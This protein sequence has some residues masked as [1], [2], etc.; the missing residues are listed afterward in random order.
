LH[1]Q[2]AGPV[3][4]SQYTEVTEQEDRG[5][6]DFTESSLGP[7]TLSGVAGMRLV[8]TAQLAGIPSP[9]SFLQEWIVAGGQPWLVTYTSD[10]ARFHQA[11]ADVQRLMDSI[12]FPN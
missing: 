9:L 1:Q 7:V 3:T 2:E 10:P 8:Y 5:L 11:L 4:L 6:T 12:T